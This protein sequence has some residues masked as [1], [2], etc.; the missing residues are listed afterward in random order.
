MKQKA[1][2]RKTNKEYLAYLNSDIKI[3]LMCGNSE[4]EFFEHCVSCEECGTTFRR[5][6][7]LQS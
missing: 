1:I 5:T 7:C 4:I 2:H 6:K 3:C